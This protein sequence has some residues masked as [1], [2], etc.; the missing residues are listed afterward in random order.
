M[1]AIF[2]WGWVWYVT[3]F[4]TVC[5]GLLAALCIQADLTPFTA[6]ANDNAT[7]VGMVLTFIYKTELGAFSNTILIKIYMNLH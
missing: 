4:S 3:I 7:A 1:A 6:G 5:A 2:G